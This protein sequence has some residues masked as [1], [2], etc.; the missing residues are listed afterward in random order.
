MESSAFRLK[1]S[2]DNGSPYGLMKSITELPRSGLVQDF[3]CGVRRYVA[4]IRKRLLARRFSS[5]ERYITRPLFAATNM[6][7]ESTNKCAVVNLRL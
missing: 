5:N 4:L 3:F 2:A 7:G 1:R 6:T